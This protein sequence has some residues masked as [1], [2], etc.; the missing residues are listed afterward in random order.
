M[1]T[2]NVLPGLPAPPR[3]VTLGIEDEAVIAKWEHAKEDASG[4]TVVGYR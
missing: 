2:V 3:N 4:E 1:E